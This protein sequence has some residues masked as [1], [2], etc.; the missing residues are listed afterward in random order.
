MDN[1]RVVF[2]SQQPAG[3]LQIQ[4]CSSATS[5]LSRCFLRTLA[6]IGGCKWNNHFS[7]FSSQW[8]TLTSKKGKLSKHTLSKL[9]RKKKCNQRKSLLLNKVHNVLLITLKFSFLFCLL[10]KIWYVHEHFNQKGIKKRKK[11][12]SSLESLKNLVH[13]YRQ[14]TKLPMKNVIRIKWLLRF[15]CLSN[16]NILNIWD[17]DHAAAKSFLRFFLWLLLFC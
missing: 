11:K 15:V 9:L 3:R 12:L 5:S 16:I 4:S 10:C 1:D 17:L 2:S 8:R 14:K 13:L 7:E 6:T